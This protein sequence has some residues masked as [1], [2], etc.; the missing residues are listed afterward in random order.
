[1]MRTLL[2][3]GVSALLVLSVVSSASA[4]A[5]TYQGF[6]KQSGNPA[7]G[8][9][10]FQ[11]LLFS[12]LTGGTQVGST[13]SLNSVSVQNGLFTVALDFGA[14]WDGSDRYLEIRVSPAGSGSYTTLSPRVKINPTPY[15]IRAGTANPIGSAGGD[16]SGTYP[17]PTVI[18]IQGRSIANTAPTAGQVLKWDGSAWSPAND[19]SD[20]LWSL[21]GTNI[22]YNTGNVGIGTSSPIYRLHV[23]TNAGDRAVFGRHTATTGTTYGVWGRSASTSGTGVYGEAS[24]S[25][26]PST[27]VIGISY[28]T[29]GTGVFGAAS[30]TSGSATGVYGRS[31]STSGRG[32][33]GLASASTGPSTGV[34]GTSYSTEG[35][36]VFGAASAT[37]GT[38]YGG[39]FQSASTSGRGVFGFA[40]ATTGTTYGVL[41]QSTSTN[42]TGVYGWANATTGTTYG[43]YGLSASTSGRGVFGWASATTGATYGVFGRSDSPDG[44]GGYFL[45]RGYFSDNVGI[46]TTSPSARLH[47]RGV[48]GNQSSAII[49]DRS[50]NVY[51]DWNSG[52]GG[53]LATWDIVCA[54]IKYSTLVNRSDERLKRD[55]QPLDAPTELQR[56][57]QL[58]PVSYF[59]RDERLNEAMQGKPQFGFIAQELQ[60]VFPELVLE[61]SDQDEMLSVNYQALFP[62]LVNAIQV[63]QAEIRQLQEEL[64]QLRA[65]LNKQQR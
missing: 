52:W 56:L 30:A 33:W 61:G 15:A 14:V 25:T 37:S 24:A 9:Y 23:E 50:G 40:N 13:V 28:S 18:R 20:Q 54:G 59:W 39:R 57:L 51:T 21:S 43:V 44:Y 16:L 46:G 49:T 65:L 3:F 1:M 32:V 7:N 17:N 62:L 12:T 4:Q 10:D 22:F 47:V 64:R 2:S 35:T 31:T 6:L 36:G 48:S 41:G 19:L 63:Q 34:I 11:F 55:I 58:R 42:G 60:S 38:T 8:N 29:E 27:G 26:G 53:G 45:G 5:F